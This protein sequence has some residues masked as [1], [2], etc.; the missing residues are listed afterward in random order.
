MSLSPSEVKASLRGVAVGLLTP[1]DDDLEIDYDGIEY[2]A[3]RLY[4]AGPQTFL[5]AAN[6][7]EYHSLSQRER[8]QVVDASRGALPDDACVLAGVGGST[9]EARR[10]VEAYDEIGVDGMM[11]MPPD[12]T[13]VHEC[14]I[15]GYYEKLASTTDTPLVPYVRGIDPSVSFLV[16]LAN[17][18]GVVGV[19]YALKDPV[20]LGEATAAA[21]DDI[22]WVNGLAE[23]FAVSFWNEGIE[24]FSA[25]VSNFRPAVG[26]ELFE[27]LS[28]AEWER[29]REI[30]NLCMPFQRFRDETGSDNVIG[31]A[32]SVPAVKEALELAGYRAGNGRVREPL[33]PLCAENKSRAEE[34]YQ[35]L[36]D[37]IDRVIG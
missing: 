25:G 35:Q 28:A 8:I 3:R 6:I 16:D 11:I 31:G 22:V 19:K 15:I 27:A 4:E 24:G 12:H 33:Q 23:P 13:Y 29:A 17:V 20:K 9:A 36:E 34:L 10:L 1:F 2:N 18:D 14:G 5:A 32:V 30:R 37:D 26:L 7:S 21:P